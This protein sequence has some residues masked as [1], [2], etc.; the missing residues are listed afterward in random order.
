MSSSPFRRIWRHPGFFA[1]ALLLPLA[2]SHALAQ[3]PYEFSIVA[4]STRADFPSFGTFP[5]INDSGTVAFMVESAGAPVG[6]FRTDDGMA[7]RLAGEATNGYVFINRLGEVSARRW[8]GS[9]VQLYKVGAAGQAAVLAQTGAEYYSFFSPSAHLSPTGTAVFSAR[10]NPYVPTQRGIYA[11]TGDGTTSLVVDNLG[12][13][14]VNFGDHP[15]V[16][17]AGTVAFTGEKDDGEA[18]LYVG[19]VGGNGAVTTVLTA[20]ASPLYRW[21]GSPHI[22]EAGQIAFKAYEDATG[23][24]GIF[25]VDQSG[26]NLRTVATA[27]GIGLPGPYSMFDS[28]VLNDV[29]T[30]AFHA[31]LDTG[32]RGIYT[33][34]DPAIHKVIELNDPLFGSVVS[35][36]A[37]FRGLNNRNELVFWFTL[38]DGRTGIAKAKPVAVAPTISRT[39]GVTA[40][41]NRTNQLQA[42]DTPRCATGVN[43]GAPQGGAA[44]AKLWFT[45]AG[46]PGSARF[47]RVQV[48]SAP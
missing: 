29:G 43:L 35:N 19:R 18:G 33:G 40:L 9:E 47:Y 27:G 45:D 37:F 20:A 16:N 2:G 13:F 14:G 1:L 38:A 46:A 41:A 42:S 34:S 36:L 15:T 26:A 5:T 21:D 30:V 48:V 17:S 23:E 31:R 3:A 44:G 32:G 24:P 22:N 4:D 10:K 25:V 12:V 7:P 8:V 6:A 28:P 11:A 39:N